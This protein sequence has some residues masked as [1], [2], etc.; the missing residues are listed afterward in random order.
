MPVLSP[1]CFAPKSC[2]VL[3]DGPKG[4]QRGFTLVELL[5]AISI[6]ALLAS[7]AVPQFLKFQQRGVRTKCQSNLK[8]IGFSSLN[9][10]EDFKVFPWAKDR[11]GGGSTLSEEREAL[12]CLEL[13][14]KYD[15]IDKPEV[16][17]CPGAVGV[18]DEEPEIIEDLKERKDDFTLDEYTCS[19]TWATKIIGPNNPSTTPVSADKRGGSESDEVNHKGG[20]NVVYKDNQVLWFSDDELEDGNNKKTSKFRRTLIGF[21]SD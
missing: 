5:V 15:Y 16:Y 7:I 13:L 21:G 8:A 4:P 20:R 2:V 6:I 18:Y 1:A 17:V 14:Y 3:R 12:D 11:R 19:Y 9:Y 10:A